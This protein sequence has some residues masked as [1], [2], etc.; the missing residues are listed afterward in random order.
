MV[1]NIAN[2]LK[3][4]KKISGVIAA[5]RTSNPATARSLTFI[6]AI[7]FCIAI[8]TA[9]DPLDALNRRESKLL[10]LADARATSILEAQLR[11]RDKAIARSDKRIHEQQRIITD[12]L[13]G[14]ALLQE[15]LI[16]A[17]TRDRKH[18]GDIARLKQ[19]R[20][21]KA[22]QIDGMD[23]RELSNELENLGY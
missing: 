6:A 9:I 21:R 2:I 4:L 5:F 18:E 12:L 15:A 8:Y 3:K 10:G 13:E 22:E 11:S 23:L 7:G 17:K 19:A 14:N 1:T 16:E 20:D